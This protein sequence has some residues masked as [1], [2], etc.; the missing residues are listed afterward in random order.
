MRTMKKYPRSII[1]EK[2]VQKTDHHVI[3]HSYGG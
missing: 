3:E 2:R 1:S